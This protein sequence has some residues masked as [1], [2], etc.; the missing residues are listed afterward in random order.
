MKKQ[1]AET[2]ALNGRPRVEAL[3]GL[4]WLAV[5]AV[6][7]SHNQPRVSDAFSYFF[8]NGYSGVTVFFVLSGFVLTYTYGDTFRR[9]TFAGVWNY[10]IARIARIYPVYLLG[11]LLGGLLVGGEPLRVWLLHVFALQA[12]S[13][14]LST[15]MALDPPA[16]AVAVEMF[17]YAVFPLLVFVLYPVIRKPRNSLYLA[18]AMAV[19][20]AAA[21]VV[22]WTLGLSAL[23]ASDPA[24]AHRWLYRSPA[25]RLGDFVLGMA[26]AGIWI[27]SKKAPVSPRT[28]GW[29]SWVFVLLIPVLMVL[30][31]IYQTAASSDLLYAIP[32]AALIICLAWSPGVG[33]TR[34][35]SRRIMVILG[36]LSY[37][38]F[39]LHRPLGPYLGTDAL[40]D[41][42]SVHN[43][44]HFLFGT[45]AL[46]VICWIVQW[47]FERPTRAWLRHRL[48]TRSPAAE[49]IAVARGDRRPL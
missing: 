44:A 45:L 2:T 3:T 49:A 33:L 9:P 11:L 38:F 30:P 36:D 12:W 21:V 15:A 34:L 17:L 23:P 10:G 35:L 28:A 24:S 40:G 48:S 14:N 6:F 47:A 42:V 43:L 41:G 4:R 16:W 32:A 37:V 13:P 39:L 25:F 46:V 27:N 19:A 26:M 7:L 31:W 29:L 18:A 22:F 1:A 20:I 8:K 5:F